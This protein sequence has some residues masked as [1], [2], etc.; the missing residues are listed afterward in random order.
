ML[1]L[2]ANESY[3]V[4]VLVGIDISISFLNGLLTLEN[5]TLENQ[6]SL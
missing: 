1:L 5:T 6:P 3:F 2:Y 4:M